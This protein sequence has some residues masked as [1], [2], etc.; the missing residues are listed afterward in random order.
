MHDRRMAEKQFQPMLEKGTLEF[1]KKLK[2]NNNKEWFHAHRTEYEAALANFTELVGDLIGGITRFDSGL[3]NLKPKDTLFRIFRD[4]RFARDKSPYKHNLGA[5]MAPGGRKSKL[6]GYYIHVEPGGKSMIAGGMY[7]PATPE[8]TAVRQKIAARP[9]EFRK[10]ISAA[11]FKKRFGELQGETL[12][13][14]PRGFDRDHPDGDLLRY[15]GYV[16]WHQI[17]D[18]EIL[19]KD[20]VKKALDSYRALY[21]LNVYLNRAIGSQ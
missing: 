13:T 18:T 15:K 9:E 7:M 21:P 4:V 2:R 3:R 5:N 11:G 14:V 19:A 17:S 8:L 10:I 16:V 1:L 20:L 6:A 12:K